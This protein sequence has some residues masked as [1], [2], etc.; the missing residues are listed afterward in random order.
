MNYTHPFAEYMQ[1]ILFISFNVINSTP[2][3]NLKRIADYA[4]FGEKWCA[5]YA[6]AA[7]NHD[8]V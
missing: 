1:N 4:H 2:R 5:L 3:Q 7:L 8:C 6:P